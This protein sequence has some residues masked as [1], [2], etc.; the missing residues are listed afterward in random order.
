ME[1]SKFPVQDILYENHEQIHLIVNTVKMTFFN[2]P[3]KISH[4]VDFEGIIRI[5][6]RKFAC[7]A[8]FFHF[9]DKFIEFPRHQITRNSLSPEPFLLLIYYKRTVIDPEPL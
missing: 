5:P 9:S 2:F 8:K 4:P 6:N 1:N 3:N 7:Q